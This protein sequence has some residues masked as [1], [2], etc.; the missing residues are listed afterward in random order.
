MVERVR[1]A[2]GNVK[3]TSAPGRGTRVAFS[4][5]LPIGRDAG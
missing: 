2:R 4:V 5:P 3:V 1:A